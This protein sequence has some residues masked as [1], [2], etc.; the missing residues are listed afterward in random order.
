MPAFPGQ[1]DHGMGQIESWNGMTLR[2]YFAAQV[3]PAVLALAG[4]GKYSIDIAMDSYVIA[5][6]MMKTRNT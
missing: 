1:S 5:D 4:K 3:L 2:D 6:A